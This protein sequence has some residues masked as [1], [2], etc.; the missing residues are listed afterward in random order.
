M[1]IF[2][3]SNRIESYFSILLVS[4]RVQLFEIL[5]YLPS[6]ISYLKNKKLRKLLF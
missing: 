2:E 5:E 6:P 1:R 3:I 4:K